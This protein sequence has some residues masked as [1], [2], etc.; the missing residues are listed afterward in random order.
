MTGP[1]SRSYV[2]ILPTL[3]AGYANDLRRMSEQVTQ[4]FRQSAR[5]QLNDL[6]RITEQSM[7]D[8]ANNASQQGRRTG[9]QFG[10]GLRQGGDRSTDEFTRDINGRLRDQHGRFIREG[11][12]AGSGY[13]DGIRQG[14]RDTAPRFQAE[15]QRTGSMFGGS[16]AQT[17]KQIIAGAVI[18][19]AVQKAYS[20]AK[21]SII[22]FNST[23]EQSTIG[24]TTML[25]SGRKA[26]QFLDELQQFAKATPFDFQGLVQDSQ[27]LLGMGINAHDIIPD[28][29]ALGDS[30]ASVGGNADELNRTL[31]AFAQIS[32]RGKVTMD[33]MNQLLQGGVPNA[34]RILAAQF[35]VTTAEM[36]DMIS[37]GKVSSDVALPLLVKGIEHG[38]K[39]TAGLGG[40]MDKQSRTFQG[41]LSNIND[42]LQQSIA[43]AFRPFFREASAG[44]LSLATWLSGPQFQH[45]SDAVTHGLVQGMHMAGQAI[46][47]LR[48]IAREAFEQVIVPALNTIRAV[49]PPVI[50]FFQT[51]WDILA[52]VARLV[53]GLFVVA[54]QMFLRVLRDL[55]PYLEV[56]NRWMRQHATLLRSVAIGVLA[57]M[58]AF[59]GMA[60]VMLAVRKAILLIN[61]SIA[62]MNALL[63][64]N[65]IV[66]TVAALAGLAAGF[67]YA[68]KHSETFR[69][70]VKDVFT[71]VKQIISDVAR[72]ATE[73]WNALWHAGENVEHALENVGHAVMNAIH[74]VVAAWNAIYGAGKDVINFFRDLPGVIGRFFASAGRWL[75]DAGKMVLHGL[76]DGLKL[77]WEIVKALFYT[78]PKWIISVFAQ[79]VTWLVKGG[80]AILTG[81][82][83]GLQQLWTRII[84]PFFASMGQTV[85][86]WLSAAGNW[87][88]NAGK[89]VITGL[90]N[91]LKDM[92]VNASAW[93]RG[94]KN[95]VTGIF[96]GA[97]SWLLGAG[98]KVI[99]GFVHGLGKAVGGL[100]NWFK[101]LPGRILGWLGIHSP[102]Q[103]A[104]EA[105][106]WIV[107]AV[108]K[109]AQSVA[110][111][112][113]Q[114]FKNFKGEISSILG[115]VGLPGGTGTLVGGSAGGSPSE[116]TLELQQFAQSQF[117][118]FGWSG[119]AGNEMASLIKLWNQESGWRY[120]ATNPTSG[121]YGIP[122]ALPASKLASAGSDWQTNPRTQIMWGL[123]YIK[124]RYGDPIGAWAHEIA[125]NWYDKG[126][127]SI[128]KDQIAMLHR[129]EMVIPATF[130]DT[131]RRAVSSTGHRQMP[132]PWWPLGPS[133][134]RNHPHRSRGIFAGADPA[135]LPRLEQHLRQIL[136]HVRQWSRRGITALPM[137]AVAR[138]RQS[139]AIGSGVQS[140]LTAKDWAAIQKQ[141]KALTNDIKTFAG[142]LDGT[143][144]QVASAF[145]RMIK[146]SGLSGHAL[147]DLEQREKHLIDT[148]KRRDTITRQLAAAQAHYADLQSRYRQEVSSIRSTVVGGF[149]I[150]TAGNTATDSRG[151]PVSMTTNTVIQQLMQ[152]VRQAN[153]YAGLLRKLAKEGLS[154]SL[155]RQ[156]AEAGPAAYNAALEL[157]RS[158]PAQIAKLNSEY[159]KLGDAGTAIGTLG[160]TA[161]YGPSINA[162]KADI[163]RLTKEEQNVR[164]SV[165]AIGKRITNAINRDLHRGLPKMTDKQIE[166]YGAIVAKALHG[167]AIQFDADGMA[168]LVTKKQAAQQRKGARQ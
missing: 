139:I 161:E 61:G 149:D 113:M 120:N 26:R 121:A 89:S 63:D 51:L 84:A 27:L 65:P 127:W 114:F 97:A 159:S 156:L 9:E 71:E 93:L 146:A 3:P 86:G 102:P 16:F 134:P 119:N 124:G 143:T 108:L 29:T 5:T 72:V 95:R 11:E 64:I 80:I 32:A 129:N 60:L 130:A 22:G 138:L 103:W 131:L 101:G 128:P 59:K 135:S 87:L 115:A 68:Y 58:A 94:L 166:H 123:N 132:P 46:Q 163:T 19:G 167:M 79:A 142:S 105:G 17:A 110:G 66:L 155:I 160:A 107:K 12:R 7:R 1:I 116:S 75:V 150:T 10:N 165:D 157:S 14:L 111:G 8:L 42:A 125:N 39:A 104:I 117:S 122:Q 6:S 52:P 24:F 106:E 45:I 144:S 164:K 133:D 41:A 76:W 21:D 55:A 53:A 13:G 162:A 118:K 35:H 99:S 23:L 43:K 57:M 56:V 98:G 20:F 78:I 37:K 168:R 38:T 30:V 82:W 25:G 62:L 40:M 151:N 81:L 74:A 109:G 136:E 126:S 54:W 90:W 88:I 49:A 112:A 140:G 141:A 2:E 48:P 153:A 148:M 158:T 34:L 85:R 18:Y 145:N 137:S 69:Q 47:A 36:T 33:N 83:H 154:K 92:W 4:Q 100:L 152:Q 77:Q 44:V 31:L 73:V 96:S 50:H 67:I 91:G 15:G 70:I 147:R 28:L